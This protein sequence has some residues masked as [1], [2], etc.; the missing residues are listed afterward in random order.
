MYDL[1]PAIVEAIARAGFD[2]AAAN[3]AREIGLDKPVTWDE[4]LTDDDREHEL[5]RTRAM[6]TAAAPVIAVEAWDEGYRYT[7]FEPAP[8]E[9][10]HRP[11][12]TP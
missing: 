11:K 4:H 5:V 2:A 7:G 10:P 6:L 8:G 9:N 3:A 12:E 1:D